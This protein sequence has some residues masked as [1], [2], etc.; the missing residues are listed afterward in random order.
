MR[1][2]YV[3]WARSNQVKHSCVLDQLVGFEPRFQLKKGVPLSADFPKDVYF[4]LHPDFPH[5]LVLIDSLNNVNR[6]IVGSKRLREF[7]QARNSQC[8]EYLPVGIM[9]HKGKLL[10]REYCII[11]PV[12]PVDCLNI[13]ESGVSWNRIVKE[14]IR[15]VKRVVLDP[16]RIDMRRDIFRLN[17]YFDLILVRREVAEAIDEEQFT[18]IRWIEPENY[19]E[20]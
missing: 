1:S 10:S 9:G 18:G 17:R 13:E 19:P 4:T 8:T 14:K 16:G 20:D 5:N 2:P 7:F 15:S 6:V 11:H 12:M 3:I